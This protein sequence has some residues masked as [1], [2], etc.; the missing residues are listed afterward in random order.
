MFAKPTRAQLWSMRPGRDNA[1]VFPPRSK[2][3]Q[4]GETHC[5]FPVRLT[6]ELTELNPAAAL[7][8]LELRIGTAVA[9][10]DQHPLFGDAAGKTYTHHYLH[11]ILRLVLT[12]LYGLA[13]ALFYTWHSFRSGL[14]TALHAANVP[15]EMIM[16]ICA[17]SRSMCI[18]AW[19]RGSTRGSSTKRP[20]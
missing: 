10:R 19:A 4:W 1:V 15:D 9:D 18:D 17:P 5:P 20:P 8:D 12:Y 14:A 3:D 11:D 2:P 7:R 16:L 13:V 6:Y